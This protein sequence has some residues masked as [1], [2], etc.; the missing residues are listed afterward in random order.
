[1]AWC[2]YEIYLGSDYVQPE[3]WQTLFVALRQHLGW[4]SQWRIYLQIQHS[5]V[6]YYLYVPWSIP[7]SLGLTEFLF[8]FLADPPF[9][10]PN[11]C[12]ACSNLDFRAD[13]LPLT[14]YKIKHKSHNFCYLECNFKS[15]ARNFVASCYLITKSA[16]RYKIRRLVIPSPAQFLSIDFNKTRSLRYK[17]IPKYLDSEKAFRLTRS[18]SSQPLFQLDTFPYQTGTQNLELTDFDFAKHS[19]VIGSSGSGKSRFLSLLIDRIFHS[20]PDDYKV[21]VIDPHDALKLDLGAI[22]NQRIIDFYDAER[23]VDLFYEEREHLSVSV[24]LMLETFK[25]LIGDSYNGRLERV[26]RH[27]IYLLLLDQSFT[28]NGLRRLLSD[29]E[30]RNLALAR[31]KDVLPRSVSHFFLT[32]FQELRSGA[33]NVAFAPIMAFIDEMQMVP[34]MNQDANL[35]SLNT[36]V[37]QNFL[38]V[39]SLNRLFLGDQ[40][41]R[42]IAGLLLQ[43]IFLL[44]ENRTFAQHLVLIIDE[45]AVIENP[46]LKRFLSEM[47]KY[48]VSVILAGQYF[49][50]IS[51]DLRAGI[52]ANT[53]NYYIFRVSRSDAELLRQNLQLKLI[54][55]HGPEDEQ[56]LFTGLKARECLVQISRAGELYSLF[57]AQ[58]P[59][60]CPLP[61][62]AVPKSSVTSIVG[63]NSGTESAFTFSITTNSTVEEIMQQNSTN[64]KPLKSTHTNNSKPKSKG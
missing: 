39:F 57:K 16:Q 5:T 7:S 64:R 24:E 46:I 61:N 56:K 34:V 50:Q 63:P 17:K 15:F 12:H 14:L 37:E 25:T 54:G 31:L 38:T 49:G 4:H 26:L 48:Q 59:E 58:T 10:I 21:I 23:S 44:A 22:T 45:V 20:R 53:T 30:Y 9:T 28:F 27:S 1:M 41:T 42:V 40:P 47:R 13:S 2:W 43:Q 52:L 19:L 3:T 36:I 33:Y 11:L 35:K 18:A 51:S 62:Q 60:Y 6:H 32:E 55:S 8:K 29:V